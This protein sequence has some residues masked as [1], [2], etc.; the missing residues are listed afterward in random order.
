MSKVNKV[1]FK[2]I[3]EQCERDLAYVNKMHDNPRAAI[4]RELDGFWSFSENPTNFL[5]KIH[6]S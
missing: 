6:K 2:Q 4:I 5:N 3:S 1:L